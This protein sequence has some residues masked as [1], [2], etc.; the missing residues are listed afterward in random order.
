MK[1]LDLKD[2]HAVAETAA[3]KYKKKC[4]WMNYDELYQE[5]WVGI[6]SANKYDPS[7]G[8]LKGYLYT[9]AKNRV[10]DYV[11]KFSSSLSGGTFNSM[12]D[13]AKVKPVS[14]DKIV[15]VKS[16]TSTPE[17]LLCSE[18]VSAVIEDRILKHCAFDKEKAKWIKLLLL[19]EYK[20]KSLAEEL[21][22]EVNKLYELMKSVK[23]KL[24]TDK[25]IIKER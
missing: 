7:K 1:G 6:L 2:G 12:E 17:E 3:R 5:A 21:K 9:A 16:N 14:P 8:P 15:E 22:I 23:A 13:I 4:P 19:S 24:Q 20:S 18:Q 11:C 25:R 10:S